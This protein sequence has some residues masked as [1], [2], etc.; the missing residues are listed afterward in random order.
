VGIGTSTPVAKLEVKG[1]VDNWSPM[2]LINGEV[3]ES[4][5]T[6]TGGVLPLVSVGR[7]ALTS[8]QFNNSVYG[9][10]NVIDS[11]LSGTASYG[12]NA[13]MVVGQNKIN[14]YSTVGA[15]IPSLKLNENI[16]SKVLFPHRIIDVYFHV[17]LNYEAHVNNKFLNQINK[18]GF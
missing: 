9:A 4:N 7:I 3:T 5:F 12:S 11:A 17:L 18:R 14:I 6:G 8:S 16:F 13:S 10:A 1:V 15:T 2:T